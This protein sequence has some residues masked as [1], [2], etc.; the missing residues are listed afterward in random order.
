MTKKPHPVDVHVGSTLRRLRCYAGMSQVA[1]A[2]S[3]GITFQQLQKYEAATNRVSASR[4]WDLAQELGVPIEA[5]FPLSSDTRAKPLLARRSRLCTMGPHISG[6]AGRQPCLAFE[7]SESDR[8]REVMERRRST[9]IGYSCQPLIENCSCKKVE[10][11]F[12]I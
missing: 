4:L 8:Q 6:H 11:Q 10:I 2:E 7:G 9:R 1:L 3:V 12:C 5:L